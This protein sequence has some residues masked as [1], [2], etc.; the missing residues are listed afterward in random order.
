MITGWRPKVVGPFRIP[1]YFESR[2]D[3]YID[4]LLA[5]NNKNLLYIG[6][7]PVDSIVMH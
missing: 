6:F 3:E 1:L 5:S 2:F 7:R 4:Q